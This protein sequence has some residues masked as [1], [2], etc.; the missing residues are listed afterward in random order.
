MI[1]NIKSCKTEQVEYRQN[2]KKLVIQS[3]IK[4][5]IN[6]IKTDMKETKKE[7]DYIRKDNKHN[8]FKEN[9]TNIKEI[10]DINEA[11]KILM[12]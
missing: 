9:T 5:N 4:I 12:N 10:K 8:N 1:N 2:N 11:I 7:Y 3:N 6:G